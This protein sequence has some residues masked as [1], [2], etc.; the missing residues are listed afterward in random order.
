[1]ERDRFHAAAAGVFDAISRG[2]Y[3]YR[4]L[5]TSNYVIDETVTFLL[6]EAGP[7]AAIEVLGL[8]RGSPVLRVLHVSEAVE[9]EADAVFRRFASSHVSY[10]DCTTKVLMDR[11]DIDTAFSFDRDLEVLGLGKIP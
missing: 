7:R 2:E 9:A 10:T 4:L 3:P 8:I 11:A 5:Y 1:M 6:Y